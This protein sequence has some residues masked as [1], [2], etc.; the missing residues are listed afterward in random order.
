M[1]HQ[2]IP[3]HRTTQCIKDLFDCSVAEASLFGWSQELAE[4]T[5][6][7]YESIQESVAASPVIN[8]DETGVNC[9]KK[10][11]WFH[12]A[13]TPLAT[14][15]TVHSKRGQEAMDAAGILPEYRGTAVH[16]MW[17]SYFRYPARHGVCNAHVIRELTFA[18]EEFH[19]PWAGK[20]KK[21][22]C[23]IHSL[24]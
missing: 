21:L 6:A 24:T 10:N 17:A 9:E 19:Q 7:S 18:F 11:Y 22:L 8:N 13:S 3:A 2:L 16:D 23:R 5:Q 15:M 12:S 4:K 20:L 1:Q 14:Y